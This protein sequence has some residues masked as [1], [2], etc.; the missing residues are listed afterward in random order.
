MEEHSDTGTERRG[1]MQNLVI[2]KVRELEAKAQ[3]SSLSG[4]RE[5]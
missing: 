2:T 1:E 5:R 4:W 3:V